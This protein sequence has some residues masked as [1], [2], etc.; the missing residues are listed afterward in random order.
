MLYFTKRKALSILRKFNRENKPLKLHIGCGGHYK[1]GWVNI[2]NNPRAKKDLR[3]NVLKGIPFPDN[4]VDYI[5][6]EHF[7]EHLSYKAGLNF[8][9]EAFR[10]LKPKGVIRTAFP[11]IDTLID[12]HIKDTWREMEWVKLIKAQWYPS[13]CF[14][15]NQCIR[16]NG[17]HLYMYNV[18]ELTRRLEEAGFRGDGISQ[19]KVRQS[20]FAEMNNAEKRVDSSTVEAIKQE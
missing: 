11:D 20:R 19:C 6:N 16:E 18:S 3:L 12:A 15:L 1:E 14:M 9:K 8:L 7:I 2:D 17:A 4:S 10:V 13:G 5:F